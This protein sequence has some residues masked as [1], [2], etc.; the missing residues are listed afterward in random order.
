MSLCAQVTTGIYGLILGKL[1]ID[2]YGTMEVKS[3]H[4]GM[5]VRL[6]FKERSIFDRSVHQVRQVDIGHGLM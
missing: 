4:N 1:Y 6:K 5:C 3:N 2:H